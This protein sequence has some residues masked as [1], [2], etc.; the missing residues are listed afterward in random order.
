[1]FD[2]RK[3]TSLCLKL[4]PNCLSSSFLQVI[5]EGLHNVKAHLNK[6]LPLS[7]YKLSEESSEEWS[8]SLHFRNFVL[9]IAEF[10]PNEHITSLQEKR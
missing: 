7:Y 4:Q 1:M 5:E 10:R 3:S 9:D 2:L 8:F 6:Q